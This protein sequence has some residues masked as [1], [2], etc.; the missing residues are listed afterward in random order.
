MNRMRLLH[1]LALGSL[2]L[3]LTPAFAQTG[4]QPP[5]SGLPAAAAA[6]ATPASAAAPAQ[7]VQPKPL[8]PIADPAAYVV[9]QFGPSFKVDP[10]LGP[11]FADLDGDG[12]EDVVF[13][14]TSPTPLLAREEFSFRVEDP[15]DDY[16]GSGDVSI[17]SQFNVHM[18]GSARDILIVFDWSTPPSAQHK[19]DAKRVSKFVLI[20]TPCEKASITSL[21]LKKKNLHAIEAIDHTR[22]HAILFWDGKR[23]RWRAVGSD[24][25]DLFENLENTPAAQPAPKQ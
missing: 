9:S 4:P 25:D 10:K 18:D 7:P 16:F 11:F 20:N 14:A 8:S 21:R 15:Y 23:W 19:R 3:C 6:P 22:E 17:T 1:P 13:F 24:Q 2:A 12:T 5:S